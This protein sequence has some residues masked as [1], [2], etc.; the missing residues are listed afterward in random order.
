MA[1]KTC[2][3]QSSCQRNSFKKYL[4]IF[5]VFKKIL[6]DLNSTLTFHI[7]HS[8]NISLSVA[9][10]N[11]CQQL[12]LQ[13]QHILRGSCL[14]HSAAT[15]KKLKIKSFFQAQFVA[16]TAAAPAACPGLRQAAPT[17]SSASTKAQRTIPAWFFGGLY[18]LL[19]H[20]LSLSI[21]TFFGIVTLRLLYLQHGD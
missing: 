21:Y 16:A 18:P 9:S 15:A 7:S 3:G 14:H 1:K 13:L 11:L 17:K 2:Q 12:Q 6:F 8:Y 5:E 4:T 20:T 19:P 10:T